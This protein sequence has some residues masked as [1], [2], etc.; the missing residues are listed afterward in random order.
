MQH[1]H[2]ITQLGGKGSQKWMQHARD[3]TTWGEELRQHARADTTG[4][5]SSHVITQLGK[6]SQKW[7][8]HVHGHVIIQLGGEGSQ[9]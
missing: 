3:D 5:K 4:G 8:Q 6:S 7:M 9:K 2:V 1:G